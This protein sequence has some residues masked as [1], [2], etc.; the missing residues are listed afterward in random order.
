MF[1]QGVALDDIRKYG[2]WQATS[3]N[4][5]LYYDDVVFRGMRWAICSRERSAKPTAHVAGARG[6][7]SDVA[8]VC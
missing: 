5:Y 2:R 4:I 7:R 1:L 6:V 3:V 8:Q